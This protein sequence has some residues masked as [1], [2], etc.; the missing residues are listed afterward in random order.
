[1]GFLEFV[2]KGYTLGYWKKHDCGGCRGAGGQAKLVFG[3]WG[4]PLKSCVA[5]QIWIFL[6][7]M[8]IKSMQI[9]LIKKEF[10]DLHTGLI[11]KNIGLHN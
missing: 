3:Q 2:D 1:M 5:L 4:R 11:K 8:D 6:F 10:T 9:D 7:A